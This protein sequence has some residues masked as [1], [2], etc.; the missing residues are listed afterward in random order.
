MFNRFHRASMLVGCIVL[1]GCARPAVILP[2]PAELPSEIRGR[3]LWNTERAYVYARDRAAADET[4]AWIGELQAHLDRTYDRP[5]LGK[6]FVIITDLGDEEGVVPTLEELGRLDQTLPSMNGPDAP[7]R[8]TVAERRRKLE[9]Q[10]LAEPLA[11]K[12][13]VAP[14]DGAALALVAGAP[15][16]SAA[17][18]NGSAAASGPHVATATRLNAVMELRV[19]PDASWCI[20]CPTR[21]LGVETTKSFAPIAVERKMGKAFAAMTAPLIPVA[22]QEAAKAFDL[23]RDVLVF[24]LWAAKR[25]DWSDAKRLVEILRYQRERALRLSPLLP[26]ALNKAREEG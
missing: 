22:A 15:P 3:R 1:G 14:L 4:D 9:E 18:P 17:P 25:S 6:G 24:R 19:P 13:A 20:C 26:I 21:K 7:P 12:I 10:G 8:M 2:A 11:L 5:A 23:A 16:G